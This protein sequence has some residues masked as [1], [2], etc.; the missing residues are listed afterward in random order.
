MVFIVLRTHLLEELIH[1]NIGL[2]IPGKFHPLCIFSQEFDY[3]SKVLG[4]PVFCRL[5]NRNYQSILKSVS[6]KTFV[7]EYLLCI[8]WQFSG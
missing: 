3:I 8:L 4:V 2:I 6:R 1:S 7:Q 5:N